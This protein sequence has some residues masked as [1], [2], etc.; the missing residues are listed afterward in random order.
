MAG[1]VDAGG[2]MLGAQARVQYAALARLRWQMFTNGLRSNKGALELGARTVSFVFYAVGGLAFGVGAGAAAFLLASGEQWK[3]LPIL[4]WA[5]FFAWQ[6]IPVMLASFQEQFDLGILLRFPVRFGSYFL[7]YVVFGLVDVSTIL[8]G[9]GCLGILA[10]IT[11]ARPELF[12]WTALGLALFAAF[13]ILLVRAIFAWIDRWLA[14]RKTREILG[15]VFMVLILSLQLLNPALHRQRHEENSAPLGRNATKEQAQQKNQEYQRT[16][17]EF[18]ARYGPWLGTANEVQQWLPPGLAARALQQ[19]VEQQAEPASGPGLGFESLAVL[20][21]YVLG[22]GGALA[23]RLRAEYRGESLGVAP[24]RKKAA[25]S[26]S[27]AVQDKTARREGGGLLDGSGPIA[28]V[29]EKE[30][31]TLFRTLPLLYSVGAPLLLV[32]IFSGVFIRSGP[33]AHIFPLAL[34]LCLVYAQLGFTRLFYNN[35]GAEGTGIQ[36]YFLSPTPI[37]TVLLAKNLFHS[38]MFGLTILIA[39]TLAILRLGQPE[40]VVVAGTVAWLLFSLPSNL[41][42]GNVFS[43]TMPY[44]VNPGRITRQ[45]GSQANALG[46]LL[47]QALVMGVGAAVFGLSWYLHKM[48]LAVPIFLALAVG[49][50]IVWVRM[51]RNADAMANQRRD[52]LIA[53]LMKTE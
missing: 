46:A 14:Q 9:L 25:A 8:G 52:S 28:A 27:K 41:A 31:R 45:G 47:V 53:T 5:V 26:Q 21:L 11:A 51:L 20:G 37:R 6:I 50:V 42:A 29:M 43:L 32:L 19:R 18:K 1:I 12:A 33:R 39:G 16:K 35:L 36:L 49:A 3:Y 10:G 24:S 38:V 34:P 17:A 7:L 40:G 13:N 15:A 30:L 23:A 44:R 4:F 2:G 22:A 48:W